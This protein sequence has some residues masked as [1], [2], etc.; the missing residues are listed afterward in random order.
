MKKILLAA[1]AAAAF[2]AM[3]ASAADLGARYNYNKAP[4]Y[5]AP[6]W[7]WTG[8]YV[9]AH[10]GGAFGGNYNFNGLALSDNDA[11]FMGGVQ[12]GADW[13]FYGNWVVGAEGQYSWLSR[14][15]ASAVFPAGYVY[16]NDQR[17]LGSI[18]ARLGY[19]FGAALVYVKGG[20]AYSDNRDVVT[21]AGVPIAFALD[22]GHSSGW[23]IGGGAE[24]MFAPSWSVKAE[25]QYYDFGDSRFVA[26]AALVPFGAFHNDEHTLKVGVNYRFNFSSPVVAR[27]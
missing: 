19:S 25:Y 13:Q 4:A 10:L 24:Y 11:R 22:S 26:P 14:N 12:A 6:I 23:T 1:S 16:S 9:G 5:A 18:T 3:P 20:Y 17:G 15:N 21:F 8:F 2:A 27:Y 7:T